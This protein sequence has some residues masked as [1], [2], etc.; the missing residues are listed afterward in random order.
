M[1]VEQWSDNVLL[2]ELADDP[3]FTDD[4]TSA[5]E[6][7]TAQPRTDVLLTFTN[8]NYLNSSNIAKLLKLRK[9]VMIH[10]AADI[11]C[12]EEVGRGAY[13]DVAVGLREQGAGSS[14]ARLYGELAQD[15]P[16]FVDLLADVGDQSRPNTGVDSTDPAEPSPSRHGRVLRAYQRYL[17]TGSQRDRLLLIRCGHLPPGREDLKWW[18]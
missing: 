3:Q 14:W 12:Y 17:R 10:N 7:C 15:F 5:I 4:L 8:V 6:S 16:G 13:G 18:Q 2:G 9:L 1:T 11:D